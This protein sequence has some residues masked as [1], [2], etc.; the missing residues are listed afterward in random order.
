MSLV[1]INTSTL[2]IVK[3]ATWRDQQ[4]EIYRC[5]GWVPGGSNH[6]HLR[7]WASPR[8][9]SRTRPKRTELRAPH[10]THGA[11]RS[12]DRENAGHAF[13]SVILGKPVISVI[14][15]VYYLGPVDDG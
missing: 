2:T 7:I 15:W 5:L 6:L 1:L 8:D 10:S 12:S 9:S 11:T 4:M 13:T 14:S 3:N